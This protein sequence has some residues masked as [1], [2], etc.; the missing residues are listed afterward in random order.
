MPMLKF[1]ISGEFDVAM[2]PMVRRRLLDLI[3]DNPGETIEV[4]LSQVTFIDST[5]I[6]VLVGAHQS[7]QVTNGAI[8]LHAPTPTVWKILTIMGLDKYF[9][10]TGP[11][12]ET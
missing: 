1:D 2:A 3:A 10:C 9:V 7:G 12:T 11:P 8:T 4:D 5:A 6:G